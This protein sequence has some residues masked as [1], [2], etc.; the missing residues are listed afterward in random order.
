[1]RL[2]TSRLGGVGLCWGRKEYPPGR[3]YEHDGGLARQ[4]LWLVKFRDWSTKELLLKMMEWNAQAR[5]GWGAN[6]WFMGKHLCAWVDAA[7]W[8]ALHSAFAHFDGDDSW[9][10]LSATL[11]LFRRL[12]TETAGMLGYAYPDEVDSQIG[13]FIVALRG[14]QPATG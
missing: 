13:G 5:A 3:G 7:T 6:T 10:S 4:E 8:E 12:A 14:A 1:M 11:D 2:P 9:L